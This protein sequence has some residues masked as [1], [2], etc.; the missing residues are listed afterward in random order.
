MRS[1]VFR[2]R[3]YCRCRYRIFSFR[4]PILLIMAFVFEIAADIIIH[5]DFFG[6]A[7]TPTGL[8]LSPPDDAVLI[9]PGL[10]H[11]GLTAAIRAVHSFLAP[12]PSIMR[13]TVST[14]SKTSA[15]KYICAE[16]GLFANCVMIVICAGFT[17]V[18]APLS[19]VTVAHYLLFSPRLPLCTLLTSV[20][21]IYLFARTPHWM[22]A[23]DATVLR[24][25]SV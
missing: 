21:W 19:L 16:D 20:V 23:P 12:L 14:L 1:S 8:A 24:K 10:E 18:F 15:I 2:S 22:I 6:I 3:L 17:Y 13:A 9:F 25:F 5:V 11:M 4:P 7:V